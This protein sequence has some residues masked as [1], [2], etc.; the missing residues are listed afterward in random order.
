MPNGVIIAK[1]H[2]HMSLDDAKR[3][4]VSDGEVVHVEVNNE[5]GGLLYNVVVRVNDQYVLDFHIDTDE[6]NA[7]N[8]NTGDY[9]KLIKI[10]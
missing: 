6:G 5:R 3:F 2:I 7:F 8:L 1:R 10:N 9:V 4:N